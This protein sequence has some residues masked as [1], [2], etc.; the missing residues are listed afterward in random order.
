MEIPKYKHLLIFDYFG[1]REEVIVDDFFTFAIKFFNKNS[2]RNLV[3]QSEKMI[4]PLG[5]T[6]IHLLNRN[7]NDF[8]VYKWNG[9]L[10]DMTNDIGGFLQIQTSG[11]TL[12]MLFYAI[13][14]NCDGMTTSLRLIDIGEQ[15]QHV[16]F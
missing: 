7:G 4:V 8:L 14:D 1:H 10:V 13:R 15:Y 5:V 11:V 3:K 9:K 16:V 12:K 2:S 6:E